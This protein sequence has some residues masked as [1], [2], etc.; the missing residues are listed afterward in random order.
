MAAPPSCRRSASSCSAVPTRRRS[1]SPPW[2]GP[3]LCGRAPIVILP[4]RRSGRGFPI[5]SAPGGMTIEAAAKVAPDVLWF[6]LYRFA[7]DG[8]RVGFDLARRAHEAGAHVL[9]LTL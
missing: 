1:A 7:D 4:R 5:R 6:Q 3:R 2:A 9:M 8:H